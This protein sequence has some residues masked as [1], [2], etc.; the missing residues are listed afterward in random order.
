MPTDVVVVVVEGAA[1]GLIWPGAVIRVQLLGTAAPPPTA[2]CSIKSSLLGP[3]W[4]TYKPKRT[5]KCW[6][7]LT[8]DLGIRKARQQRCV[9]GSVHQFFAVHGIRCVCMHAWQH[10]R[11][12]A[13]MRAACD[14][15]Q[16]CH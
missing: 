1:N 2:L 10:A 16:Y 11:M 6:A 4:S 8:P 5:D 7:T 13:C 3:E 15:S 9:M 12:H 14:W